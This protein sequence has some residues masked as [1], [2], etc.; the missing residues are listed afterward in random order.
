MSGIINGAASAAVGGLMLL[1][2]AARSD[3]ITL[4]LPTG[5]HTPVW[6]TWLDHNL[7]LSMPVFVIVLILFM[8]TLAELRRRVIAHESP[9][10]IAQMDHLADIWTSLFFG[11]GV[12]WTAIGMRNALLNSLG[13]PSAT[14][15]AGAVALLER[16]VDGGM[17]VALSTTIVGGAGGYLM[18]VIKTIFVGAD[19]KRCYTRHGR[20]DAQAIRQS[21]DSMNRHLEGISGAP[22]A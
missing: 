8:Q 16:M 19:L 2:I 3:L 15:A 7:G 4:N 10:R 1:Y 9:D 13:D 11:V 21:L 17:L 18:R 20:E 14:M 5:W 12:I 22:E 6:F